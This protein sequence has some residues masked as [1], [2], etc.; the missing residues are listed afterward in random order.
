MLENCKPKDKKK[1][2]K[3]PEPEE[4]QD[5]EGVPYILARAECILMDIKV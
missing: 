1:P 2:E 4:Q 3:S 5:Q